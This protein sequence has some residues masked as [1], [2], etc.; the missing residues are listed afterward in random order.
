M[1]PTTHD[2]WTERADLAQA[3]LEKYFG[4]PGQQLLHNTC[5]SEPGDDEV[6]N[7]WWLAHLID[8]RVDAYERTGDP[9]W[10][11]KARGAHDNILARNDEALYNDYFDDMLWFALATLRLAGATGDAALH[12]EASAL[13]R[14][15]GEK[16][17]ND[18]EG[19]GIAWR[20]QQP[21]YKNTPANGP[22]VILSARLDDGTGD[23]LAWARRTMDWLEAALVTPEGFVHDGRNRQE[24]G[25]VDTDWR[26]TY[27]QGLY[28]GA[29]VA[30]AEATG[31][32]GHL[33]KGLRTARTAVTELMV[34][35]VFA[36]EGDGGDEG[37]F[38]G[39]F[40][41]YARLL[42]EAT[43]DAELRAVIL[44]STETLWSRALAGDSLLA[45]GDW[46]E[47]ATGKVPY[48]AQLSAIM[49]TEAC[50]ALTA[51]R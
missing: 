37:L 33:D 35:G 34:G 16:G 9:A 27:N 46:R 13:W 10:L 4:A 45:P 12:A 24:D 44:D 40:Y 19:G 8:V 36:H 26:Y 17:W 5:P 20:V 18:I 1:P 50:A 22:F 41:R 38:K 51:P 3:S 30:L 32:K 21:Y 6:F 23:H 49:A 28:I 2:T 39:I 25:A 11:D 15:V 47:P 29:C 43:G 14:H 42:A 48:S 7:Y 31:D